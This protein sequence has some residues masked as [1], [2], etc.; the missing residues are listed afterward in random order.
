VIAVAVRRVGGCD[1]T[2]LMICSAAWALVTPLAPRVA[3]ARLAALANWAGRG[4]A[5][6][7]W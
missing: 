6:R 2:M 4:T 7:L 5:S 1:V 3:A